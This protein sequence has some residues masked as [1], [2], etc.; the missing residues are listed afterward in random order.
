MMSLPTRSLAAALRPLRPKTA[1]IT[2]FYLPTLSAKRRHVATA[3]S[4]AAEPT[5]TVVPSAFRRKTMHAPLENW[6]LA[7]EYVALAGNKKASF[8]PETRGS[9]TDPKSFLTAI[10]RGLDTYADKFKDW[11]HLFTATADQME[12]ELG[13]KCG[14]RKYLQGWREWY[15]RGIEPYEVG[16]PKRQKKYLKEREKVKLARLKRQGLA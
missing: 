1:S 5:P 16:I 11:G 10:G 14:Q 4:P 3:A 12:N 6:K 8:V 7:E 15:K 2:A 9:I 13:I